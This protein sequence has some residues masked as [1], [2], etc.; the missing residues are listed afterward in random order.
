MDPKYIT[1]KE[2]RVEILPCRVCRSPQSILLIHHFK[3]I[4]DNLYIYNWM[5]FCQKIG[6]L[7][8]K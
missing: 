1:F 5:S 3:F 8:S 7:K 2:K 6:V 4:N